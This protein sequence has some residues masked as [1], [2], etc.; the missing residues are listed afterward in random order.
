MQQPVLSYHTLFCLT[1]SCSIL[2]HPILSHHI[3]FC[4][5]FS[6]PILSCPLFFV[7]KENPYSCRVLAGGKSTEERKKGLEVE[8]AL[9]SIVLYC[10]CDYHSDYQCDYYHIALH[11][12]TSHHITLRHITQAF[13]D[14]VIRFLIC[15]DLAARGIDVEGLPFV[16]NMT[17]PDS[18]E[19]YIHRVGE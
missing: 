2:S 19:T 6:S 11:H 7:A 5:T 13:K 3:L 4:L 15:T 9:C 1:L 17:L 12:I 8:S 14:G 16:I 18:A 10:H